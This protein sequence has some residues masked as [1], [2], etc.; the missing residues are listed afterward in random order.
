MKLPF[1]YE[2]RRPRPSPRRSGGRR[3]FAGAK[4]DRLTA[5]WLLGG[6]GINETLAQQLPTLCVGPEEQ[7]RAGAVKGLDESAADLECTDGFAAALPD[8][9]STIRSAA[10]CTGTF[11]TPAR[12]VATAR[13]C[14][15]AS[16][17]RGV[18]LALLIRESN[19]KVESR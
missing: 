17:M 4:Q 2:L 19:S 9:S 14:I 7:P 11:H 16:S 1:G 13:A 6:Q 18:P 8:H 5:D 15:F 12:C 10:A 3:N